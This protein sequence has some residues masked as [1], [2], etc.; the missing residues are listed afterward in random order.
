MAAWLYPLYV[1]ERPVGT[2]R[3]SVRRKTVG[4]GRFGI[5]HGFFRLPG[6]RCFG[7]KQPVFPACIACASGR[8]PFSG[9][10]GWPE[11][12]LAGLLDGR[13]DRNGSLS[14]G[15]I[16]REWQGF[17]AGFVWP[18]RHCRA[19][20]KRAW[21]QSGR[22]W[23]A[24]CRRKAGKTAVVSPAGGSGAFPAQDG[25]GGLPE[26]SPL[27]KYSGKGQAAAVLRFF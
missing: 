1:W 24:S 11:W 22:E 9:L 25:T 8:F 15:R 5:R 23:P 26:K 4:T 17:S 3:K 6:L 20:K 12:P 27:R 21:R 10:G 18:V 16:G 13:D 14:E 2:C 19:G 7:G